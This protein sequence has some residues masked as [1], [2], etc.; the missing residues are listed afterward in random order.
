[1]DYVC[2]ECGG[3][4][5]LIVDGVWMTKEQLLLLPKAP[6]KIEKRIVHELWCASEDHQTQIHL[7]RNL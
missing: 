2:S 7:A 6:K 1:M 3:I 4:L 5:N